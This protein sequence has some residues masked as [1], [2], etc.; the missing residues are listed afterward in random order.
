MCERPKTVVLEE[1]I[2]IK[3]TPDTGEALQ[4]ALWALHSHHTSY[5]SL[6]KE[7]CALGSHFT[8]L[9]SGDLRWR[10][11]CARPWLVHMGFEPLLTTQGV[12]LAKE[13]YSTDKAEGY[14]KYSQFLYH[15]ILFLLNKLKVFSEQLWGNLVTII[16]LNSKVAPIT[17]K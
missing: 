10:A 14:S 13:T 16:P 4:R 1:K 5:E 7:G 11:L 12:S 9:C 15:R 8:V 6:G 17:W 3:A 2:K